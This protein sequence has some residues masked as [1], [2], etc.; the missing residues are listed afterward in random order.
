MATTY[1]ATA[2]GPCRTLRQETDVNGRHTLITDE[3]EL[4]GGTDEGPSPHE[5]LPA[6]LASCISTML[7]LYVQRRGWQVGDIVVDVEYDTD[8]DP[9]TFDV[10]ILLPDGLTDEQMAR[11][12]QVSQTCPVRRAFET[13]FVVQERVEIPTL[14]D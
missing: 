2:T 3:P 1:T 9:R 13:G 12:A 7:A 8:T 4:L 6:A 5:L 11:L 10:T 14:A